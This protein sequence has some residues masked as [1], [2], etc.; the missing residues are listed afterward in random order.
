MYFKLHYAHFQNGNNNNA[1]IV[2]AR[3]KPFIFWARKL[4]KENHFST[5]PNIMFVNIVDQTS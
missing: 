5:A 1:M 3:R 4:T 2:V